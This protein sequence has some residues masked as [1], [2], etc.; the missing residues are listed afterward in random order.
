MPFHKTINNVPPDPI[1]APVTVTAA[2]AIGPNPLHVSN[3]ALFGSPSTAAPIFVSVFRGAAPVTVLEVTGIASNAL[4]V[5]GAAPSAADAACNPGDTVMM[6]PTSDNFT[7]LQAAA[8]PASDAITTATALRLACWGDSL[9]LGSSVTP[10]PAQLSPLI[11]RDCYNG[12]INGDTSAQILTRFEAAPDKLNY[13]VVI[14]SG[15]NDMYTSTDPTPV[16]ANLAAMVAA[17]GH[18]RYLVLSVPNTSAETIGTTYYNGVLA[19][20]ADLASVYGAHYFDIRS[21]LISQYNPGIPQDVTDHGNDVLP[22]SLRISGDAIHLNTGGYALVAQ[23]VAAHMAILNP[24]TQLVATTNMGAL[25]AAP[26]GPIG[27]A[28]PTD[29]AFA[30]LTANDVSIA[31]GSIAVSSLTVFGSIAMPSTYNWTIRGDSNFGF[32]VLNPGSGAIHTRLEYF[33]LGPGADTRGG[34]YDTDSQ[35]WIAWADTLRDFQVTNHLIVGATAATGSGATGARP[36]GM[37]VGAQWYDTTLGKPIWWSGTA[38]H[39]ATGAA[40]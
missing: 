1:G 33:S 9:T 8:T 6:C 29:G 21:Y 15:R 36:A 10:Y 19:L 23:Q 18:T 26:A 35:T 25:L 11:H 17:L 5:T 12:G 39:D 38:W 22:S 28:V 40:V 7:E 37:G 4:T 3:G 30:N 31:N 2:R 34:I 16:L 14:W 20:N 13:A 24:P 27:A 32:S